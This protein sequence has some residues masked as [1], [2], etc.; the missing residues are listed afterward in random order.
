MVNVRFPKREV[1]QV[2]IDGLPDAG[3]ARAQQARE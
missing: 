3:S 2:T 1:V